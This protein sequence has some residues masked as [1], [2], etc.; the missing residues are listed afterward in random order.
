MYVLTMLYK[1]SCALLASPAH[2]SAVKNLPAIQEHTFDPWVRKIPWE[3]AWQLN[4]VFLLENTIDRGAWQSSVHRVTK[5]Q[6]QLNQL[7]THTLYI[8]N[9]KHY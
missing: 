4:P 3:R 2:G 6:I 1:G 9:T 8:V 7:S 5:S